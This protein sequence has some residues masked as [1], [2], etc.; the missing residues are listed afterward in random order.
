MWVENMNICKIPWQWTTC[1][2]PISAFPKNKHTEKSWYHNK[3]MEILTIKIMSIGK[4]P[5]KIK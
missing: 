1:L 3:R 4:R 2:L 5:G